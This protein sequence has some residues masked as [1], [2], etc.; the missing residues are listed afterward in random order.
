MLDISHSEIKNAEKIP[1]INSEKPIDRLLLDSSSVHA[2]QHTDALLSHKQS[3]PI[4][5]VVIE[6]PYFNSG[7]ENRS[8]GHA[9]GTLNNTKPSKKNE[10]RLNLVY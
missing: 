3:A 9:N 5:D 1:N 4:S 6:F 7:P 10:G 2:Y 8:N